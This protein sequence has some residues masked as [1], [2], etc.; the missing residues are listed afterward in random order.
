MLVGIITMKSEP[1]KLTENF[2]RLEVH[3]R[4]AARRRAQVVITPE[5]AL[6]GY[7]FN[8][9]PTSTKEAMLEVAQIVPEG[10]YIRRAADLCGE[11][12]IYL[13]FGFLERQ[14]EN[15]FNSCVMLSPQGQVVAHYRKVNTAGE[16]DITPGSEL[17]PFDTVFGRVG[18]LLCS[19]RKVD[20]FSVLAVQG[21]RIIIIPMNGSGGPENTEKMRWLGRDNQC[22]VIIAN[23]WSAVIIDSYGEIHLEKYETECVSVQ[24]VELPTD[25]IRGR[26]LQRRPDLYEP[27]LC[28][29]VPGHFYNR[30]G[31]LTPAGQ[32]Y[33]L[34]E[35][36]KKLK[37]RAESTPAD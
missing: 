20:N 28:S 27:L 4:E 29:T 21:A 6:D 19:D 37:G 13:V 8:E 15:L 9:D 31:G 34:A 17:K 32:E 25:Q 30:A 36:S 3:A 14:D 1:W 2:Q 24:H 22:W 18:F 35:R 5:S 7:V 23:T 12:G 16:Y 33:R 10:P 26:F 11:L